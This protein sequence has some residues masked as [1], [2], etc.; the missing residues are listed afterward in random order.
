MPSTSAAKLGIKAIQPFNAVRKVR[1]VIRN[2][3]VLIRKNKEGS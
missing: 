1:I 3:K 2:S